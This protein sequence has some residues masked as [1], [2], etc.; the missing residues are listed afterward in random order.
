MLPIV[1]P[2]IKDQTSRRDGGSPKCHLISVKR[3]LKS[4]RAIHGRSDRDAPVVACSLHA[5]IALI[6]LL[7]LLA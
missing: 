2:Y 3:S 1:R 6:E 4:V 5:Y 7:A